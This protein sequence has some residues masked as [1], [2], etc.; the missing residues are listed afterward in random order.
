[1][2]L[3]KSRLHIGDPGTRK[4][5]FLSDGNTTTPPP[6]PVAT[7]ATNVNY[8]SLTANWLASAT[9]TSYYLDVSTDPLFGSF[10][11]I[12]NNLNVGNVLFEN[13]TG[14]NSNE[15]YYFRVRAN[16]INGTSANSNTITTSTLSFVLDPFPG[17]E[18]VICS[19]LLLGNYS[20]ALWEIYRV[21]DGAIDSFYPDPNNGYKITLQSENLGGISLNTWLGSGDGKLRREYDQSGN[22]NH[23]LQIDPAKMPFVVIAG[24]LQVIGALAVANYTDNAQVL[25]SPP[26]LT[27]EANFAIFTKL[28]PTSY[29][30]SNPRFSAFVNTLCNIQT[31]RNNTD[32]TFIRFNSTTYS[33]TNNIFP[34]N[35][36]YLMSF[37]FA[38]GVLTS[39]VNGTIEAITAAGLAPGA[40]SVLPNGTYLNY[41]FDAVSFKIKTGFSFL[42]IAYDSDQAINF[43]AINAAIELL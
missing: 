24:V 15:T 8:F 12:Y 13:V 29:Q 11:G 28:K 31:G 43:N 3:G 14:L 25:E 9:A 33:S 37:S 6:A 27:Q 10:V 22:N 19:V 7:A 2:R 38:S 1:M 18:I 4:S 41:G 32:H 30:D 40:D 35:N 34:L 20:G 16:N 39:N 21:S 26:T 23:N 17:S 5:F 42:L 36:F